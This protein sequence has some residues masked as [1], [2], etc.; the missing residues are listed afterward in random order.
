MRRKKAIIFRKPKT[1]TPRKI[2]KAIEIGINEKEE[3]NNLG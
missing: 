2:Q 1:R 3:G